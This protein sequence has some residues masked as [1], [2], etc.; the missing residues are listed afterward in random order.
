MRA[1]FKKQLPRYSI[2]VAIVFGAILA[3]ASF[4]WWLMQ[5]YPTLHLDLVPARIEITHLT[6][7]DASNWVNYS[8]NGLELKIPPNWGKVLL[9]ENKD[10]WDA[11]GDDDLILL[12]RFP[13]KM[14]FDKYRRALYARWWPPRLIQKAN[15]I[16]FLD[17]Q[18]PRIVE[19]AIGSWIAFIFPSPRQW[20]FDLFQD[21]IHVLA[22][23]RTQ[24]DGTVLDEQLMKDVVSTIKLKPQK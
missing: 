2:I 9:K 24:R 20:H 1:L 12:L 3:I 6:S 19:Q 18:N 5:R 14:D 7:Q 4:R 15:A 13:K 17:E 23:F 8:T 16:S 22:S 11:V 10:T 21:G